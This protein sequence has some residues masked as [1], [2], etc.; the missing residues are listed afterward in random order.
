MVLDELGVSAPGELRRE[1]IGGELD[2]GVQD[3][4][5]PEQTEVQMRAGVPDSGAPHFA[6]LLAGVDVVAHFDIV[7]RQV[8]IEGD[9]PVAVVD[10]HEQTSW[11]HVARMNDSRAPRLQG[12]ECAAFPIDAREGHRAG[13]NGTDRL[14]L[15]RCKVDTPVYAPALVAGLTQT[16]DR[17]SR[18]T[19]ERTHEGNAF[20][21][22]AAVVESRVAVEE[23]T[24]RGEDPI[25]GSRIT[26]PVP[27]YEMRNRVTVRRGAK[28]AIDL[29]A[30]LLEHFE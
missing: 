19:I 1:H 30:L 29:R 18:V 7:A 2:E 5:I 15:L 3:L 6:Q 11:T 13:S 14:A 26:H 21:S 25:F 16:A 22:L 28:N 4:A 24:P 27:P 12:D 8:C 20:D 10:L 23:A 9:H 17:N